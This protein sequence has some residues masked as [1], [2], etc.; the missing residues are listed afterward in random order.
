MTPESVE[1]VLRTPLLHDVKSDGMV[2]YP[3]S[4]AHYSVWSNYHFYVNKVL[5][6]EHLKVPGDWKSLWN[7]SIPPKVNNFLWRAVGDCLPS[8]SKLASRGVL[9]SPLCPWCGTNVENSWHILVSCSKVETVWRKVNL[10][11]KISNM[12]EHVNDFKE[13]FFSILTNSQLMPGW[14]DQ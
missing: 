7:I 6:V 4:K 5:D 12:L 13:L 3:Y 8:K 11:D 2:W 10:W 1:A 9:C 14:C